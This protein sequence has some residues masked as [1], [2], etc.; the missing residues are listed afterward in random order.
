MSVVVVVASALPVCVAGVWTVVGSDVALPQYIRMMVV[1]LVLH[2]G[3]EAVRGPVAEIYGTFG[4]L[5]QT[6]N[7]R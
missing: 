1:V 3:T 2:V 6:A 5:E 4:A 7:D